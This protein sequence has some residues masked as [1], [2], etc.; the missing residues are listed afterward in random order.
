M[1][2]K[3][4][5]IKRISALFLCLAVVLVT[6]NLPA[7]TMKVKAASY[8]D[9]VMD[10][11][12]N[13]R[14]DLYNDNTATVISTGGG[15]PYTG[16]IV[17]PDAISRNGTDY[18]VTEIGANAFS[19]SNIESIVLP[20]SITIINLE[21]F[22]GCESLTSINIPNNV[23]MINIAAFTMCT[24]LK[25]INLP[26][27]LSTIG[28]NAFTGCYSL[29]DIVIPANVTS[30]GASAFD[31]CTSL[32]K[33]EFLGTTTLPS[34]NSGNIP[35]G[36]EIIV[37]Y[38]YKDAYV[39]I[40]GNSVNIVEHSEENGGGGSGNNDSNDSHSSSSSSNTE[41][42]YISYANKLE[43]QFRTVTA[44]NK[45]LLELGNWHSVPGY[46]MERILE[47]NVDVELTY[48]YNGKNYDIVI[49]AGKGINLHIPWYGPLLM[50]SIYG[51]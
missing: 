28:R 33:I 17:I 19:G 13:I 23:T 25:S 40:L 10:T 36:I 6:M 50:Y 44:G 9:T 16:N 24:N 8:V 45:V 32:N 35:E 22:L 7:F 11:S 5:I 2:N 3:N 21:A 14:Y 20:N 43:E 46:M 34:I 47:S 1:K 18:T 15:E 41:S 39:S 31:S 51:K 37:P 30:I 26:D 48:I 12:N 29:T 38:G 27:S 49:P 4:K 42:V